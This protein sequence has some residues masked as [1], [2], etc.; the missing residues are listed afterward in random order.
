MV[1]TKKSRKNIETHS[2]TYEDFYNKYDA[3]F[4]YLNVDTYRCVGNKEDTIQGIYADH[5]FSYF[6]LRKSIVIV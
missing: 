1:L 4:D 2:C 5:I 3:Q 6:E